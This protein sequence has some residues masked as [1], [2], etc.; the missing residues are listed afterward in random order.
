MS[1]ILEEVKKKMK[2]ILEAKSEDLEEIQKRTEA[3]MTQLEAAED[4]MRKAA[5]TMS[6][7]AYME[8]KK[9][10]DKAA[11]ILELYAS[12][13]NRI[14]TKQD[15]SEQE[16]DEVIDSLL[17]HE[18]QLRREYE[19]TLGKMLK[20]LRLMHEQY[21]A[22]IQDTEQTIS[23]WT[24]E[25]HP[26]YRTFG[27]TTYYDSATGERTD[28]ASIPRAVHTM[29]YHGGEEAERLA[30]YLAMAKPESPTV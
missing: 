9:E 16:S 14:M 27:R 17:R 8:A 11:T 24:A 10:R 18:E 25:I 3:A 26:N 19:V 20:P 15:I 12:R 13:Q 28:R 6:P 29:P 23:T 5:D 22:D 30:A 21:L 4:A 1:S 2:E 7:D